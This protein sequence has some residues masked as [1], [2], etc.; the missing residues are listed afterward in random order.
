MVAWEIEERRNLTSLI[1]VVA[2]IIPIL[3]NHADAGTAPILE[4]HVNAGTIHD[5]ENMPIMVWIPWR[6]GSPTTLLW[7]L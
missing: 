2:G 3:E 7:T 5:Q 6:S 4:S 1:P